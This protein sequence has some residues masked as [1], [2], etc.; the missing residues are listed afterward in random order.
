MKAATGNMRIRGCGWVPIELYYYKNRQHAGFSL[1]A[2][3]FHLLFYL[4]LMG[5]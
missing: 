3:V 2:V 4:I 1:W 5:N